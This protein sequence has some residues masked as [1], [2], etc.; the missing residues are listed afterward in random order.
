MEMMGFARLNPSYALLGL[1]VKT[2]LLSPIKLMLPVQ[3]SL[4]NKSLRD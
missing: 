1:R 4:Q 2:N 3:S